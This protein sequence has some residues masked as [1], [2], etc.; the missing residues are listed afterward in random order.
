MADFN[1][2]ALT[3]LY[4]DMVNVL[5]DRD[6]SALKWLDGTT[7]SNIP[8][9]AKRWNATNSY[10]EKFNGSTWS[11]LT[12]KYMI[13]VDK[14]DGCTVNDL[15]TSTTDLWTASKINTALGTKLAAS[16]YTAAD[17]LTKI[18][19][20]DGSA[21][22]LDADLLDGLHA[23]S[24]NT[25]STVV[26]RDASGNFSAGTITANLT[27]TAS[28]AT[29]LTGLTS[30]VAE[31]NFSDG[32]T[33]NIQTQLNGKLGSTAKATDSAL[34]NGVAEATT[35]TANTIVKR[36]SEGDLY[37]RLFRSSYEEQTTPPTVAADICFRNDTA[38]D[39][40][41]RFM[42][43]VAFKSW[44]TNIG[45]AVTDT[46]RDI[47][48]SVATTSSTISA[49]ATAV[50]AAY[51]LANTAFNEP[52]VVGNYYE[53]AAGPSQWIATTTP[54][55]KH[56]YKIKRSG[57]LTVVFTITQRVGAEYNVLPRGQIYINNV[58]RGTLRAPGAASGTYT[59]NITVNKNDLLQIYVWGTS[60]YND[61]QISS[62]ALFCNNPTV[63]SVTVL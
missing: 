34:L 58:A 33:S 21:S 12:A 15:G 39:N 9:G 50:K 44:L 47:T 17:V 26:A 25:G 7:D 6:I 16:D 8:S 60:T 61:V 2:P 14:V 10:F 20:V 52:F 48:D 31:L 22:G 11:A 57:I 19:S 46:W 41:M 54:T 53:A 35:A 40:Y 13:D 1:Q 56:E 49:S 5:K 37:A 23:S 51:D 45:V 43:S 18:K 62:S 42:S 24:S 30:T 3:S 36:D 55:K 27:G 63:T 29:T 4:A 32:V 59:E 38:N 28:T